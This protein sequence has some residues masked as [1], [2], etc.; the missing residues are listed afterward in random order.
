MLLVMS[1]K[2]QN[3]RLFYAIILLLILSFD[4]FP[5][6]I[7]IFMCGYVREMLQKT[8][9]IEM[10]DGGCLVNGTGSIFNVH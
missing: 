8:P 7:H 9:K 5:I 2:I 6:Q 4:F 3:L 1:L 10:R